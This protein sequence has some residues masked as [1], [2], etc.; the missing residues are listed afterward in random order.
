MAGHSKGELCLPDAELCCLVLMQTQ[1]DMLPRDPP[2]FQVTKIHE[3]L[4]GATLDADSSAQDTGETKN[5]Q[6]PAATEEPK[7]SSGK[8]EF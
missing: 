5:Q 3:S 4:K 6:D 2:L 1:L 7:A 8:E